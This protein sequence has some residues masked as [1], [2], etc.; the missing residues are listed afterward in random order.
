MPA[1]VDLPRPFGP[2]VLTRRIAAGGMA[3]VYVATTRGV[4]GFEKSVAIKVILP[5]YSEDEHF[6]RMLVEEAKICALLNHVNIGQVY[7]LGCIDGTYFIVMEYIEGVDAYRLLKRIKEQGRELPIETAVYVAREICQGL[8]YAHERRGPDGRPLHIVHRD[9]SPQNVLLSFAG[10]VKLVDFGIAKAALRSQQTEAGVIKGKYYYMSP[11]QAWGDPVDRRSDVF[12]TGLVLHELLTGRMVHRARNLPELLERV[13]KAEIPPP[14]HQRPELS[15]ELDAIVM[16]ALQR[17]PERRYATAREFAQVLSGYLHRVAPSFGPNRL[18]D[19]LATTLAHRSA[20]PRA[21]ARKTTDA[22]GLR[23]GAASLLFRDPEGREPTREVGPQETA[24]DEAD[25]DPTLTARPS[26]SLRALAASTR[27]ETA[28]PDPTLTARPS[29]SLRALAPPPPSAR[30]RSARPHQPSSSGTSE[31]ARSGPRP[32]SQAWEDEATAP[33]PPEPSSGIRRGP[34]HRQQSSVEPPPSP[35]EAEAPDSD[36]DD[37]EEPTASIFSFEQSW[38]DLTLLD[39]EAELRARSM[40]RADGIAPPPAGVVPPPVAR[41]G[42]TQPSPTAEERMRVARLPTE[43]L[44]ALRDVSVPMLASSRGRRVLALAALLLVPAL[45]AALWWL[46]PKP[47]PRLRIESIPNGARVVLDGQPIGSTPLVLQGPPLQADREHILRITAPGRR[48]EQRPLRLKPGERRTLSVQLAPARVKVRIESAPP[49]ANLYV[50]G[51]FVGSTPVTLE[52]QLHGQRI[53]LLA[54]APG[55]LDLERFVE[56]QGEDGSTQPIRLI[57]PPVPRPEV[58]PTKRRR[59]SP[60]TRRGH[61]G[62]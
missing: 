59:R 56:V 1:N 6:V 42:P 29:P 14:S 38:E 58:A 9:V 4:G 26:P 57:L 21:T 35:D 50:D 55:R 45:L 31:D 32:R 48:A 22:S 17:D 34:R 51:A 44:G 41:G 62:R 27:R 61:R 52:E 28:D 18:A 5:R 36:S 39:E 12:S 13:R 3:E 43:Q 23:A 46:W 15:P 33:A 54:K 53:R 16:R 7:D 25:P 30:A 49:G 19:L 37:E 40:A 8:H 47:P 24:R 60:R 10:E 20:K 11:E 2:Y